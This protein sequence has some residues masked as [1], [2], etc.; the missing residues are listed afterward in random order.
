[1]TYKL[2]EPL[3]FVTRNHAD[4]PLHPIY[5]PYYTAEQIQAAHA[6]G[7]D[8]MTAENAALKAD[9]K[10]TKEE[11]ELFSGDYKSAV[12]DVAELNDKVF[13]LMTE[14]VALR[15]TADKYNELLMGVSVKFK[16][17]SRHDT[18]KRYIY[19]W[20]GKKSNG[21]DTAKESKS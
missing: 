1:M 7:R 10:L 21:A 12:E 2:P 9:L 19:S 20:E 14:N 8:S 16:D 13:E 5:N 3:Y 17:E 4:H 6:A 11:R 18:A 15:V